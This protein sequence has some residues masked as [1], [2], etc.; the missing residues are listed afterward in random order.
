MKTLVKSL[1]LFALTVQITQQAQAGVLSD[2]NGKIPAK[3]IAKT[4]S[5]GGSQSFDESTYIINLGV[6]FGGGDYYSA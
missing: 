1:M 6:G 4:M 2:D 3:R 5:G